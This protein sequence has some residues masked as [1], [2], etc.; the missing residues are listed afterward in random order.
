MFGF[1]HD[2]MSVELIPVL[3]HSI[4]CTW[5]NDLQDAL[6]LNVSLPE[7]SGGSKLGKYAPAKW[8]HVAI[9]AAIVTA[10]RAH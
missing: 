5:T 6:A 10:M 2:Q 9:H 4:T 7:S 3:H 1:A 8:E